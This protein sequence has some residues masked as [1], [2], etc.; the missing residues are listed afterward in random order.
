MNSSFLSFIG[1]KNNT[2]SNEGWK[3]EGVKLHSYEMDIVERFMKFNQYVQCVC[4]WFDDILL[5]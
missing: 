4:F 3:K 1:F 5:P 2:V